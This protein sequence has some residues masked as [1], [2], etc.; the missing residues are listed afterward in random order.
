MNENEYKRS[1]AKITRDGIPK[2]LFIHYHHTY[3][4]SQY[5]DSLEYTSCK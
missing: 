5:R 2:I 4:F 1:F 3:H